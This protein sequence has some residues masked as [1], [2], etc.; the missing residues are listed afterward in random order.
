[1]MTQPPAGTN[2]YPTKPSSGRGTA[3]K[4]LKVAAT[5]CALLGCP[6]AQVRQS[7]PPEPCP[8]G[9]LETMEQ[10]DIKVGE[11]EGWSFGGSGNRYLTVSEGWTTVF[12]AGADFGDIPN[13][14]TA[15]GRLVFGDRVYGRI[16]QVQLKGTGRTVPVCMELFDTGAHRGLEFAPGS[17]PGAAR[18]FS[19]GYIRAVSSFK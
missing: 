18:V 19:V 8:P 2:Q 13:G 10:L 5:A 4:T 7:P 16:T 12:I 6:G 3:G 14:S 17:K 15:S 1:M 11:R 9:A